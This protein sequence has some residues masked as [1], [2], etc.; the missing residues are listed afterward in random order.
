MNIFGIIWAI[1]AAIII[2]ACIFLR[3]VEEVRHPYT[4]D[5]W[6]FP[7]VLLAVVWPLI[8]IGAI[9]FSPF[10]GI[11]WLGKYVGRKMMQ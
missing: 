5:G 11:Y 8:P 1:M 9:M 2:I 7:M 6:I 10:Y 4:D 3:G